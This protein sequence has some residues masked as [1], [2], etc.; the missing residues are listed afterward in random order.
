M[1]PAAGGAAR[2]LGRT[3]H[4]DAGCRQPILELG[5]LLGAHL[6]PRPL[7]HLDV[8]QVGGDDERLVVAVEV[9]LEDVLVVGRGV[10]APAQVLQPLGQPVPLVICVARGIG[11]RRAAR[12]ISQSLSP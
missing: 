4:V 2:P 6:A 5:T 3:A 1:D 11:R 12:G 9:E 10:E 8:E 7:G